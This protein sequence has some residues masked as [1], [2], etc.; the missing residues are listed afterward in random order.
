LPQKHIWPPTCFVVGYKSWIL[1]HHKYFSCFEFLASYLHSSGIIASSPQRHS[2]TSSPLWV[3]IGKPSYER[4]DYLTS[5]L[6]VKL[7]E[8]N[9]IHKQEKLKQSCLC[10]SPFDSRDIFCFHLTDPNTYSPSKCG[11][12]D[13]YKKLGVNMA[14]IVTIC[15]GSPD[16]LTLRNRNSSLSKPIP[17]WPSWRKA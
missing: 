1:K 3:K 6:G 12:L 13:V 10:D 8:V 15:N 11:I 7:C 16:W 14:T 5:P 9:L 4:L 2:N 17:E